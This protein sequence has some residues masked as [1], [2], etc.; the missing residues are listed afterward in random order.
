MFTKNIYQKSPIPIQNGLL[1]CRALIRKILREGKDQFILLNDIQKNEFDASVM[2]SFVDTQ[3]THTLV[4]ATKHVP[5]Y[6]RTM[7]STTYNLA[8]FPIISKVEIREHAD[9]FLSD[10]H[11]GVIVS[12]ATS[13]TTGTP[14][15]IR[16]DMTSVI[17]EQAFVARHLNWAGFKAG[18]KRAWIRGDMIVPPDQ[19]EGPFWRYSWFEKIIMLSSF[20][21]SPKNLK[22]YIDA[23]VNYGV[24]IIQAYP[25]SI[26][27]LAKY[28]EV[29]DQYYPGNLKSIVT[30]SESLSSED[31]QLLEKRFKCK[32]F[33][34]YGL[35]ERVAAIGNCE[36]GRYH[37]ISD[38]S[39][40]ELID[41]GN[42]RHE[43]VGTNFNNDLQPLIRY[44]TGDY[45]YLSD[46]KQCPCGRVFPII[47]RIEGRIGDYL[48]GE[49]GQRVHI[50]NHIPKGVEGLLATQFLQSVWN[51]IEVEAVVDP[52]IFDDKQQQ[53]LINNTKARLG[54]SMEISVKIVEKIQKTK[55][56]K[57][58]QAICT[59]EES[60]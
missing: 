38:Y 14:L 41:V 11:R 21:M 25:S 19:K 35:F 42:G 4:Q 44:R 52:L 16:Q 48:I 1:S 56:G 58:R 43:I 5:F 20:H 26:V 28:L 22:K 6:K 55:N 50:L 47:D 15:V 45:V 49:D 31:R 24:D 17:R 34:W 36:H 39:H 27:T 33:D 9:N 30:S 51:H 60:L 59:I 37:I 12:G 46:E 23:M 54:K 32:V 8:D 10:N 3:L 53:I 18:D 29:N 13:G 40:V 57:T 2:R 7:V